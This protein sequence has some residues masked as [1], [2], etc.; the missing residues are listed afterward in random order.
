MKKVFILIALLVQVLSIQ[1]AANKQTKI[2]IHTDR[3]IYAS[4]DAL[5]FSGRILNGDLTPKTSNNIIYLELFD[6][7]NQSYDVYMQRIENGIFSGQITLPEGLGFGTCYLK[8][9]TV[10]MI[11]DP[12]SHYV[13]PFIINASVPTNNN[14]ENNVLLIDTVGDI[15]VSNVAHS[16]QTEQPMLS[17]Y[18]EGGTL[19]PGFLQKIGVVSA[20]SQYVPLSVSGEIKGSDN[21][22]VSFSTNT[23]GLGVFEVEFK[24]GVT[25]T[26]EIECTGHKFNYPIPLAEPGLAL[27]ITRTKNGWQAIPLAETGTNKDVT[28]TVTSKGLAIKNIPCTTNKPVEIDIATLP[29]GV[30]ILTLF[31]TNKKAVCERLIYKPVTALP[32]PNVLFNKE[33]YVAGE[34]VQFVVNGFTGNY[35][36]AFT[37]YNYPEYCERIN[38]DITKSLLL[39]SELRSLNPHLSVYK[40][41]LPVKESDAELLLLTYGWRN[42]EKQ[43]VEKPLFKQED[44][45]YIKGRVLNVLTRTPL[46]GTMISLTFRKELIAI[47]V[48]AKTDDEGRFYIGMNDLN[49]TTEFSI[50]A[51][52]SKNKPRKALF[53]IET[54]R[55]KWLLDNTQDLEWI[56]KR[57]VKHTKIQDMPYT[58]HSENN[59]A[60]TDSALTSSPSSIPSEFSRQRKN[61]DLSFYS[62]TITLLNEVLKQE[63]APIGRREKMHQETGSPQKSLS[64]MQIKAIG[65]KVK[66]ASLMDYVLRTMPEIRWNDSDFDDVDRTTKWKPYT[67]TINGEASKPVF[68]V[69]DGKRLY[70]GENPKADI[71]F[72][73]LNTAVVKAD[74]QRINSISPAS[75]DYIDLIRP[76]AGY[77][78]YFT[79][80]DQEV[81]S[82]LISPDFMGIQPYI[83]SITTNGRMAFSALE[84]TGFIPKRN[85]YRFIMKSPDQRQYTSKT[86]Q[87]YPLNDVGKGYGFMLNKINGNVL[88]NIQGM[89]DKN[90]PFCFFDT[91]VV[92]QNYQFLGA[93]IQ[94]TKK[95]ENIKYDEDYIEDDAFSLDYGIS[96]L[97]LIEGTKKPLPHVLIKAANGVTTYTNNDGKFGFPE[98]Y[99]Q[100]NPTFTAYTPGIKQ[101]SFSVNPEKSNEVTVI[102][103]RQQSASLP[104][105]DAKK[106]VWKA[107]LNS[108][109]LRKNELSEVFYREIVTRNNDLYALNESQY[110]YKIQR[111]TGDEKY[112][113]SMKQAR[114]ME[115]TDFSSEIRI[116]PRTSTINNTGM[117]DFMVNPVA[118]LKAE[119]MHKFS[120][121]VSREAS[122][123]NRNCLIISFN[124]KE[125]V[126]ENLYDGLIW[127][128]K[129]DEVIVH[130]EF[131]FNKKGLT[132]FDPL[133]HLN[134]SL[135]ADT[136]PGEVM[137]TNTYTYN[138]KTLLFS[139]ATERFELVSPTKTVVFSKEL[140]GIKGMTSTKELISRPV[141]SLDKR[142][143]LVKNPQ[144]NGSFWSN[145]PFI[146]PEK[147]VL[148]QIQYLN[149][150]NLF[151]S[152]K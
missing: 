11:N 142:T 10:E 119:E 101:I 117:L 100:G 73:S 149:S 122:F 23:D 77:E 94:N 9:Y 85:F 128:D 123:N 17:F 1:I 97:L 4:G 107:Y 43:S 31:N 44:S 75:V 28:L 141:T 70:Y 12:E 145:I 33:N 118:F 13:L 14:T 2:F 103:Q 114:F 115:T 39:F 26:A 84:F 50:V 7:T 21:S 27:R 109:K 59:F 104:A 135:P 6:A 93:E 45:L 60:I 124:Q 116:K 113:T 18:P 125:N 48:H 76:T 91:L 65:E 55:H 136:K 24:N 64:Y 121:N 131:S 3:D 25:Y 37:D 15:V 8:A 67:L 71:D 82:G 20:T 130:M 96:G 129:D 30:S 57:E 58:I 5:W 38:P 49:T 36:A 74:R 95:S 143:L 69:L 152:T 89:T 108:L 90:E 78:K 47:P 22:M 42:F 99:V 88:V 40:G 19:I 140:V 53:E 138:G 16:V 54:N 63:Q 81:M 139:A 83:L 112:C 106:L 148:N 32:T 41:G 35:S 66:F 86:V 29:Q 79:L 80:F 56:V 137:Y 146:L 151:T 102:A 133:L 46:K 144:Y 34:P 61:D 126:N 72:Q 105:E 147:E 132:F 62:D 120:Y 127:I 110:V 98:S 111:L 68:V 134:G 87:W 52:D 51:F 150:I 92:R